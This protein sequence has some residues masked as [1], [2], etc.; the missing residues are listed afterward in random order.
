MLPGTVVAIYFLWHTMKI[1][2]TIEDENIIV[3]NDGTITF[4][5]KAA[6]DVDG[7]GDSHGD[8]DYQNDTSLHQNGQALN[9]DNDKYIVVPPLIIFSVRGTVLGC[10]AY[11]LNLKNGHFSEAVVGDIGPH[12]KIGEISYALAVALGIDPSPTT[13]GEEDHMIYYAVKPGQHAVVDGKTY[14]LQA[15]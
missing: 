5:S 8:P 4:T 11:V 15:T 9:A 6:V 12:Q 10:Q 7:L 3:L 13:G 14:T 1:L 2:A